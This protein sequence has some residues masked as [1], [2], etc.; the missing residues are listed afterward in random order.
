MRKI[1]TLLVSVCMVS[2][3]LLVG[4]KTEDEPRKPEITRVPEKFSVYVN[5]DVDIPEIE[6]TAGADLTVTVNGPSGA[7]VAVSEGKFR[8]VAAGNYTVTYRVTLGE[9]SVEASLTVTAL[10]S[11][12]PPTIELDGENAKRVLKDESVTL[13]PASAKDALG[14]DL[15]VTIT[16][17][18]PSAADVSLTDRSF[19]AAEKGEYAIAYSATD[20]FGN[21]ATVTDAITCYTVPKPVSDVPAGVKNSFETE[22]KSFLE[23]LNAETSGVTFARNSTDEDKNA[24]RSGA[25][26]L[27]ITS[28]EGSKLINLVSEA[29]CGSKNFGGMGT[30]S[31]WAYNGNGDAG[32]MSIYNLVLTSGTTK[33]VNVYQVLP[34]PVSG[35]E[36]DAWTKYEINLIECGFTAEQLED[37]Y[38]AALWVEKAGT[39]YIDDIAWDDRADYVTLGAVEQRIEHLFGG[40]VTIAVPEVSAGATLT[41][42]VTDP[43]G[44]P[45]D[46]SNEYAFTPSKTGEYEILYS[47]TNG[48]TTAEKTTV[49]YVYKPDPEPVGPVPDGVR[50]SFETEAECA[51]DKLGAAFSRNSTDDKREGVKS[52]AYSLK[53][54][55]S[56][57]GTVSL[58][59]QAI[60]GTQDLSDIGTLTFWVYNG[61]AAEVQFNLYK[62]ILVDSTTIQPNIGLRIPAG[63]WKQHTFNFVDCGLTETQLEKVWA[64]QFWT[65]AGVEIY[66]DDVSWDNRADYVTLGDIQQET[67]VL[68]GAEVSVEAPAVS[69]NAQL[70][71]SVT[72]P[73]GESVAV[74]DGKFTVTQTGTYTISY[75]AKGTVKE[76]TKRTTVIVTESEPE[77]IPE[78]VY[79]F[80]DFTG[81]PNGLTTF[82]TVDERNRTAIEISD[83]AE[84]AHRGSKSVH[85]T[86]NSEVLTGWKPATIFGTQKFSADIGS[87]SLW[88][89][90]VNGGRFTLWGVNTVLPSGTVSFSEATDLP[91]GVWTEIT[92][93]LTD[94]KFDAYRKTDGGIEIYWIKFTTAAGEYYL[95][96]FTLNK[97]P[98]A[99]TEGGE[100]GGTAQAVAALA[101]DSDKR[102]SA[103]RE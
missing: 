92:V 98:A 43:E 90:S 25:Y 36:R 50:N 55:T 64:I 31:F 96:D 73:D 3:L 1:L 58:M 54:K 51:L 85:F 19:V 33:K 60:N 67:S 69:A 66:L 71:I 68:V 72:G 5:S 87:I 99:E 84:N 48:K 2:A 53:I 17:T 22:E 88:V 11:D 45:V 83:D 52:G 100:S 89:R 40:G 41:I 34:V 79:S 14:K 103:E 95:D 20:D 38:S 62:V 56:A 97:K 24:V 10:S 32:G 57:G 78:N 47:A 93:D 15:A 91:A 86:V 76:L 80:E 77:P 42:T 74:T 49:L 61:G 8:P 16:V 63:E 44:N 26:S 37:T 102:Y 6:Y 30:L 81:D 12:V 4:C 82:N 9:Q 59:S 21:S 39:Y 27:K 13:V 70:V 29:V 7:A 28:V 65:N 35:S 94:P 46:Y 23:R 18:S 75:T 101:V